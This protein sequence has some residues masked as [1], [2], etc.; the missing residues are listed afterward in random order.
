[1]AQ[2][3]ADILSKDEINYILQLP[4]VLSNKSKLDDIPTG[5]IKFNLK[6]PVEIQKKLQE[7]LGIS[8]IGKM[9]IP[10]RWIK[11]D[12]VP[13][14]DVGDK[15]LNTYLVYLNNNQGK[16]VLDNMEYPIVENTGYVFNEGVKHA[17]INTGS[18]P[19]LM[20]GPM[21]ENVVAV[22]APAFI[23]YYS[24]QSNA[25][26]TINSIAQNTAN[27][28]VGYFTQG[29]IGF[30]DTW[31]I[32]SSSTG[33]STGDVTN[34]T[35]LA[36]GGIYHLY[37]ALPPSGRSTVPYQ[38]QTCPA[39]PYNAT[40]FTPANSAEFA[41]LQNYA[42]TQ[43]QY[44]WSSG[45]NAQQIYR[46][47]QNITYFNNINQQTQAIRTANGIVG[48]QPY[49]QFKT[50]TERLMYIQGMTLT[51]ARNQ[52]TGQNPSGPAGVPCSTIYQIIN[53]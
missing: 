28:V 46:S 21:S 2:T 48:N 36:A 3:F 38:S 41:T 9:D 14:I 24:N 11:G 52:I 45:S 19:R 43:P 13:H 53:S 4:E 30:T 40:N 23:F 49:P 20:I 25:T 33:T 15:F 6:L 29:N 35:L 22:G 8:F 1:M 27:Y 10:M 16:L 42:R 37:P 31:A 51:A 7:T 17:T 44:P 12:T 39:P 5:A 34:G 50:Q 26:T 47:Q 18:E 32:A